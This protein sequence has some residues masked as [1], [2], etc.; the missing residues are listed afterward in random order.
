MK[1]SAQEKMKLLDIKSRYIAA[2]KQRS[3]HS[4]KFDANVACLREIEALCKEFQSLCIPYYIKIE[5]LGSRLEDAK[6]NIFVLIKAKH[7]ISQA[8]G[9]LKEA[10]S[11]LF[12]KEFSE[13][14]TQ[15]FGDK[16]IKGLSFDE[17]EE[18]KTTYKAGFFQ[19]RDEVHIKNYII[20]FSDDTALT[21]H[22]LDIEEEMN[23]AEILFNDK[24]KQLNTSPQFNY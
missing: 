16:P 9:A 13:L 15:E 7:K 23:Q 22:T 21:W 3:P 2:I 1:L 18:T 24:L 11:I 17:K 8:Q 4:Y 5:K 12:D 6:C 20:K 19:K 10:S 14:M